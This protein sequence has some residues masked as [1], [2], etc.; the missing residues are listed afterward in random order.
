MSALNS[1]GVRPTFTLEFGAFEANFSADMRRLGIRAI[2]LEANPYNFEYF[3][4]HPNL[5]E[6]GVEYLHTAVSNTEG[7]IEF[8]IQKALNGEAVD[9]VRGNNSLF[10]RAQDG[11]EYETVTVPSTSLAE[12]FRKNGC[13]G[14]SFSAWIDVEGAI[15]DVLDGAGITFQTCMTVMVEVE[16]HRFWHGQKLVFDVMEFFM[17]RNLIP[18]AR[19]FEYSHQYNLIFVRRE[20]LE[21]ADVREA[22]AVYYSRIGRRQP[23]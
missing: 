1:P 6:S 15:G 4:N 13:A 21:R 23:V 16:Q 12:L 10:I 3:R 9:P 18:I 7:H 17:K 2:A 5:V 22:M 19:D 8:H 14:Q 11:V 20:L